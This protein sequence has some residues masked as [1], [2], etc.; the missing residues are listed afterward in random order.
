MT[1]LRNAAWGDHIAIQ[2]IADR[3]NVAINVLSSQS[4]SMIPRNCS[5]QH[6]LYVA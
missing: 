1:R 4:A 3:F 5:A 2:G 6:E